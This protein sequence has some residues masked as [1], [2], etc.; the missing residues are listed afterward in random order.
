M[1]TLTGLIDKQLHRSVEYFYFYVL[2]LLFFFFFFFFFF[3]LHVPAFFSC[4]PVASGRVG[5]GKT[6]G[7]LI[8]VS[9]LG[10]PRLYMWQDHRGNGDGGGKRSL[11]VTCHPPKERTLLTFYPLVLI[12]DSGTSVPDI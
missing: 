9:C 10:I 11:Q 7:L 8:M 3:P 4:Y 2:L 1:Q 5:G 12:P 6:P